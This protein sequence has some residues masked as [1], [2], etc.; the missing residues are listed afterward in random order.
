MAKDAA[1]PRDQLEGVLV[2]ERLAVSD[3]DGAVLNSGGILPSGS[4]VLWGRGGGH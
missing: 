2:A 3:F 1:A 4:Q